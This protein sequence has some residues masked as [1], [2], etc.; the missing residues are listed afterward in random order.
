MRKNDDVKLPEKAYLIEARSIVDERGKLCVIGDEELAF[1]VARVFW[2]SDVPAGKTRGGHAHRVCAEIIFPLKGEFKIYVH[3]ADGER[4]YAMNKS[5]QG[6]YIGPNV[7]C[8]LSDFAPG[9][10][11][12]VLASHEYMV[13]GYI[14]DYNEF[15]KG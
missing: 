10:V 5:E 11:C 2:I 15:L 1:D 6:I 12:M 9:T 8:E 13:E 14:N 7:W 4:V 3:D